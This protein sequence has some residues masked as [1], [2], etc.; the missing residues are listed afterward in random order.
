MN[1][2]VA[3]GSSWARG[4]VRACCRSMPQPGQHWFWAASATYTA[5][6]GNAGSLTHW[7]RPGIEPES[8][9]TLC[10]VFNLLSHNGNSPWGTFKQD[11][12]SVSFQTLISWFEH[13]LLFLAFSNCY[14]DNLDGGFLFLSFLL[15]LLIGVFFGLF[16]FFF[17]FLP[18]L[19]H[20]HG[21]WRFPG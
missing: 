1:V 12:Y 8:S 20:S 2:P 9:R 6:C 15:H 17:V 16:L 21:I 13:P 4:W 19:G 11:K 3:Y 14:C 10:Q 7:V 5:A 18:F